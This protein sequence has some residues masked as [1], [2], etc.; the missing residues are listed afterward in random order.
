MSAVDAVHKQSL[1]IKTLRFDDSVK[2][3]DDSL[4]AVVYR[5][6]P[7]ASKLPVS[8]GNDVSLYLTVNPERTPSR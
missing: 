5:Q 1:N 3:Y 7:E 2:D 8:L 4:N 6:S